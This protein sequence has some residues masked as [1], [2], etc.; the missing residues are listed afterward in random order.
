MCEGTVAQIKARRRFI[1]EAHSLG[2]Y[3]NQEASRRF[4]IQFC[5]IFRLEPPWVG[6]G[7]EGALEVLASWHKFQTSIKPLELTELR[8]G[9][10]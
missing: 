2:N 1:R 10:F 9:L 8:I 6:V 7:K 3:Q 5:V 4:K